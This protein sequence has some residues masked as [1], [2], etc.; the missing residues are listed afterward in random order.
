[1]GLQPE[2]TM[3]RRRVLQTAAVAGL[4]VIGSLGV[5]TTT[6]TASGGSLE[7]TYETDQRARTSPT[8][9]DGVVYTGMSDQPSHRL[10]AIDAATGDPLEEI[11]QGRPIREVSVVNGII[12]VAQD[13]GDAAIEAYDATTYDRLYSVDMENAPNTQPTVFDGTIYVG[14]GDGLVYALDAWTAQREWT[15]ETDDDVDSSPVLDSGTIYV[16]CNDEHLYAI[17]AETGDEE[18]AFAANGPIRSSPTVHDGTVYVGESANR[19]LA[20]DAG[21]GQS[22][23]QFDTAGSVSSSPTVSDG[24]VFVGDWEGNVVAVDADSGDELWTFET[25]DNVR[26]SPTV[27]GATV[28][29]VS[30]DGHCYAIDATSGDE[31]WAFD[32]GNPVGIVH[33]QPSPTVV[34]GIVY[35][36]NGNTVYALEA[37]VSGSSE[38]TR[39]QLGTLG[40]H[41]VWADTAAAGDRPSLDEIEQ[42]RESNDRSGD[43]DDGTAGGTGGSGGGTAEAD[44]L[45]GPGVVGT[46]GALGSVS[47]LLARRGSR[48]ENR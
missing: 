47:Y 29:V 12:F 10:H 18:W 5:G 14:S 4:S 35:F 40:H 33:H 30:D 28:F 38:G 44:G 11:F 26:S 34:D 21:S 20:V 1:M 27:A 41:D 24:T 15:F 39:M 31:R 13:G 2:K 32:T 23:W 8:V 43:S 48:E 22:E 36:V 46:L 3:N 19:L 9:V 45:P 7:W 17:D 42:E 37:G 16:G 25:E 6:A